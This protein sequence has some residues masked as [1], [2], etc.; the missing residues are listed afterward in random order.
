[1]RSKLREKKNK[2]KACQH[3]FEYRGVTFKIRQE[4]LVNEHT[5]A[6]VNQAN[7]QLK[8]DGGVARAISDVAGEGFRE[9]CEKF[10]RLHKELIIG[11]AMITRAGGNLGSDWV[12][13]AVGPVYQNKADNSREEE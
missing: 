10:I 11:R 13:H 8:H 4:N 3:E 6:I 2:M 1:V 9:D 12:I 7:S 5:V